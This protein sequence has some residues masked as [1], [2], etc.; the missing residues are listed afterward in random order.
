[1]EILKELP[2][3]LQKQIYDYRVQPIRDAYYTKYINLHKDKFNYCLPALNNR[4]L[5]AADAFRNL[6]HNNHLTDFAQFYR[7]NFVEG[8]DY[9]D[10]Y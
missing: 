10:D 2:L 4:R 1:M 3:P 7:L 6:F 5:N 9:Y 8:C